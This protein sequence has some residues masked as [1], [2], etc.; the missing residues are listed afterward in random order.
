MGLDNLGATC[1][2][3]TFLQVRIVGFVN[4]SNSM[5]GAM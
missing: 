1:Y 3:N 5:A 2:I 4:K